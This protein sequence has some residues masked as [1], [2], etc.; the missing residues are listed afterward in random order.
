MMFKFN[1]GNSVSLGWTFCY[2]N[3]AY[4]LLREG[5]GTG[6]RFAPDIPTGNKV[7]KNNAFV[8]AEWSIGNWR[9]GCE[10]DHNC[11]FNVPSKP[12]RRFN[13]AKSGT[14]DTIEAFRKGT[15]QEKNGLYADPKFRSPVGLGVSLPKDYTPSCDGEYNFAKA[16]AA[17]DLT[18][19]PDSPC[20]DRGAVIRGISDTFKGKAP[21]I[22]AF[23]LGAERAEFATGPRGGRGGPG[24]KAA[25]AGGASASP[26]AKRTPDVKKPEGPS[27][28]AK[29]AAAKAFARLKAE[30]IKGA[31]EGRRARVYVD[32]AGKPTRARVLGAGGDG[33]N[34]SARGLEVTIKWS[35]FAPTRFYGIAR[36]Y[37]QD[38]ASL[39]E[40]CVGN[41]LAEEAGTEKARR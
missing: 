28:E 23:E 38:H 41:G 9:K 35:A 19:N 1:V 7:L 16:A 3:S 30:I 27:T 22:G 11:Y 12:I 40:Y 14:F 17:V 13:T 15:G 5:T 36:K 39:Y 18:P 2:H 37:S 4:C 26:A 29:A 20:I 8:S 10:F 33:V 24:K 34:V 6:V 32:M 31:S 21:D 25:A